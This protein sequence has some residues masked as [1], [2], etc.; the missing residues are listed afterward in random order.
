MREYSNG[1]WWEWDNLECC[2]FKVE[3][4]INNNE[5]PG[6]EPIIDGWPLWSA[7][8]DRHEGNMNPSESLNMIMD[9]DAAKDAKK[10]TE[11]ASGMRRDDRS[12]KP[13]YTLIPRFM[14]DRVVGVMQPGAEKYGR[15]SWKKACTKE[16]LEHFKQ[17]AWRHFLAWMDDE[18]GWD[19]YASLIFNLNGAELV[20]T[21]L[22]NQ[23]S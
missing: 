5:D 4:M 6:E 22:L 18:Q 7:I 23:K 2:W 17:S 21:K 14:L 3:D 19:H 9:M 15:E 12:G 10:Q 8:P 11:Y 16:E 20:K 13:D 1:S